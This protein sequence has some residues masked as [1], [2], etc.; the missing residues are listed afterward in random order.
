[1]DNPLRLPSLQALQTLVSVAQTH[2][3]TESA[4]RL[5]TLQSLGWYPPRSSAKA[6]PW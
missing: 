2:S 4:A 6:I 1:M 5:E 3:F